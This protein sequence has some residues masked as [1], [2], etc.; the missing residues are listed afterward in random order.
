MFDVLYRLVLGTS[1][2]ELSTSSFNILLVFSC[3]LV[4]LAFSF[5][6]IAFYKL[7]LYISKF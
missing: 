6:S 2:S 5:I 3:L 1:S 7:M 4:V